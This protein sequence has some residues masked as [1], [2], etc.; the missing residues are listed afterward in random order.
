MAEALAALA[1]PGVV[2]VGLIGATEH[3]AGRHP[4]RRTLLVARTDPGATWRYG[5]VVHLP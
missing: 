2:R 3:H 1:E 4:A 5:D